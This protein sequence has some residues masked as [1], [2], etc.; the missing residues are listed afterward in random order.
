[1]ND[2]FYLR[3]AYE[4]ALLNSTDPSTQNGVVLVL[5]E[6]Q[7][8]LSSTKYLTSANYFPNNVK[9]SK[10]RW[11]RPLKYSYVEHAERNVI[12]LAAKNGFKTDGS[13]MYCAWASCADCARAIIQ[14]GIKKLVTHHDPYAENRF[15]QPLSSMWKDSIKIAL[16]MLEEAGVKVT[17]LDDK[18][19]K[20]DSFKIRFN[21]VL[22]SP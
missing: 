22:V 5:D 12:Y 1:M 19:F 8:K 20:D 10:E 3:L 9:E 18:I 2:L 15:N 21:G 4:A 17:W 7:N 6:D 16:G 13:T 11:D 14:A